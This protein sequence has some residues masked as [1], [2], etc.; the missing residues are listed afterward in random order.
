MKIREKLNIE[1]HNTS[2]IESIL[3]I[4]LKFN[5]FSCQAVV[6]PDDDHFRDA[7]TEQQGVLLSF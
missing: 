7:M 1:K 4:E 2:L 3:L 5:L 6:I